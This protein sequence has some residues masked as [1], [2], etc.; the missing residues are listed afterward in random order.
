MTNVAISPNK[1]ARFSAGRSYLI[2]PVSWPELEPAL[3]LEPAQVLQV[4]EPELQ[5]PGQAPVLQAPEQA[6]VLAQVRP[7]SS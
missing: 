5:A 1:T 4:P 7:A 2:E 3:A 6:R